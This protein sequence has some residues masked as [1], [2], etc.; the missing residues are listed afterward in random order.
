MVVLLKVPLKSKTSRFYKDF[1]PEMF[2]EKLSLN[3]GKLAN[4][5]YNNFRSTF[6]KELN[7][8]AP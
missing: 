6:L 8:H 7:K 1:D 5:F 2:E 3:L 4:D